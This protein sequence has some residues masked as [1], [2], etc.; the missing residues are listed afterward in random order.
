MALNE[1]KV[2]NNSRNINTL[3]MYNKN[4]TQIAVKVSTHN[5][6]R[7]IYNSSFTNIKK[8][9]LQ[10]FPAMNIINTT[11]IFPNTQTGKPAER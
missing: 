11:Y 6:K 3:G 7:E 5:F 1:L 8:V 2:Q 10:P 9:T 4:T